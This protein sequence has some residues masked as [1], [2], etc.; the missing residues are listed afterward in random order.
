MKLKLI[1]VVPVICVMAT[2]AI[3]NEFAFSISNL[4]TQWAQS[5]ETLF[6]TRISQ[7]SIGDVT[8]Q[9]P[10]MSQAVFLWGFNTGGDFSLTMDITNIDSIAMTAKG[11]GSFVFTDVDSDTITGNLTGTWSR[12]GNSNTFTGTLSQVVF[13]NP[14]DDGTF[15]G[16]YNTAANMSFSA[17][18]P[19]YGTIVQ[20]TAED[21]LWF[22]E[23]GWAWT[24]SGS[25][26]AT[27]APMPA[28]VI[29]GVLGLSIA[30]IKLRKYA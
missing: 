11:T 9:E 10:P 4:E 20:L 21:I 29:L 22:G 26:D 5:S 7:M 27:V 19:W 6:E 24:M 28:A 17:L 15:D 1:L 23:G 30:G 8:D 16:H 2:S 3:A 25:V 12:T 13:N 14:S 18:P